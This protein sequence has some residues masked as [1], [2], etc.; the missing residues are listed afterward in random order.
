[1]KYFIV[2]FCLVGKGFLFCEIAAICFSSSAIVFV[3]AGPPYPNF[4]LRSGL[5]VDSMKDSNHY[6]ANIYFDPEYLSVLDQN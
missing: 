3:S 2:V 6:T 4:Y 5:T 1:M